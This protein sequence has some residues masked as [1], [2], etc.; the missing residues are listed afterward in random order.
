MSEIAGRS[1]N[2]MPLVELASSSPMDGAKAPIF[3]CQGRRPEY[4]IHSS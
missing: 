2:G 3:R 1:R 4:W